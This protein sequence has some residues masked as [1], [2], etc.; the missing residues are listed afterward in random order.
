MRLQ[1]VDMWFKKDQHIGR[2]QKD[3]LVIDLLVTIESPRKSMVM[4]A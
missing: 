1:I 2:Q 4:Q 3:S